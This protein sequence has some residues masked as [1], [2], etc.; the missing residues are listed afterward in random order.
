MG[1]GL[2]FV[3][4]WIDSYCRGELGLEVNVL[5][6]RRLGEG[7]G[8]DVCIGFERDT[9]RRMLYKPE[10]RREARYLNGP[11]DRPAEMKFSVFIDIVHGADIRQ[12]GPE[13]LNALAA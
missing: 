5:G 10:F 1:D 6:W 7:P 2:D 13:I 8:I 4:S 3:A 12:R 11:Q 9:K